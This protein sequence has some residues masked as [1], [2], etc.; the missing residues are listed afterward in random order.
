[1]SQNEHMKIA[2]CYKRR[3]MK[4]S[5]L[6]IPSQDY[7]MI[8]Q[9]MIEVNSLTKRI[10]GKRGVLRVKSFLDRTQVSNQHHLSRMV[11]NCI[12]LSSRHHS[13][14]LDAKYAGHKKIVVIGCAVHQLRFTRLSSIA[15]IFLCEC[16]IALITSVNVMNLFAMD[17]KHRK[18]LM[19]YKGGK[20]TFLHYVCLCQKG[21]YYGSQSDS[22][23]RLW[24]MFRDLGNA[25]HM[26]E[27]V[28]GGGAEMALRQ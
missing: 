17:C 19:I 12:W 1:M 20:V 13:S 3:Q 2:N 6:Q 21:S 26:Y 14:V 7:T 15:E 11:G 24:I 8:F 25:L 16:K 27:G 22:L 5:D 23:G 10:Y 18:P 9:D 4:S 28:E